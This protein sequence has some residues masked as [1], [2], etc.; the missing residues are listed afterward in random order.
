VPFVPHFYQE[1]AISEMLQ[2]PAYG[3]FLDPGLGK[4]AIT[5]AAF[6][7][8]RQQ[9]IVN[10]MLVIA[11]LRVCYD[12]WPDEIR[13]W[14][15]FQHL[16]FEILH[17]PKK[18]E[19]LTSNADVFL[20]N[21]EGVE[22][23]VQKREKANISDRVWSW[24]EMLVCDESTRFKHGNTNRFKAL[25]VVLDQFDRRYILTGTP[26][27]NGY[28]DLWG[29]AYLLDQGKRLGAYITHYRNRF[30]DQS[31]DG[32]GYTI[33]GPEQIADI[34]NR[35]QDVVLRLEGADY[36][37]L[38]PLIKK[39]ISVQLPQKAR[40][41]YD[42]LE[43][44]LVLKLRGGEV[45][46][47]NAGVLSSKLRQVAG[48]FVYFDE[49]DNILEAEGELPPRRMR[50]A[51]QIHDVKIEALADLLEELQGEPLLV[52]Y[53]FQHE[54]TGILKRFGWNVPVLGA[55]TT[56]TRGTKISR[57]WNEGRIPLLLAHPAS[58][59]WGLNLQEGG[60]KICWYTPTW[61]LEH[62][63]QLIGRQWRQGQKK[64]V[65]VYSLVANHTTDVDV[66]E[67]RESKDVDQKGLLDAFKRR[68][69]L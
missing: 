32:F 9:G 47:A 29:Q 23:L 53:E 21:P 26:A 6:D 39:T 4:T 64:P 16:K 19:R 15:D 1:T 65:F 8:L 17:G 2:K 51:A 46:A 59:G 12:V 38:P 30:F 57:A 52:A 55:G 42:Q 22:W 7:L 13:K 14:T 48:G 28:M 24:P 68:R 62:Y 35:L 60:S 34:Q 61:N 41:L 50:K 69:S 49:E 45:T 3:L 66:V 11:P 43:D 36:L 44:E 58:A 5:L 27:P 31:W 33:R 37:K 54:L 40:E 56:P 10:R 63:I 67:A 25:K 20:L 18:E